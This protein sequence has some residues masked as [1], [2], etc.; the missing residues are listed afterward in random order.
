M[1]RPDGIVER[2]SDGT[3]QQVELKTK[4]SVNDN[5]IKGWEHDLQLIGQQ[6]GL[7]QWAND[8]ELG[9]RQLGGARIEVLLKG[10]RKRNKVGEM[11]QQ[12]PLIYA[13]T[14]DGAGDFLEAGTQQ[15]SWEW[16][17]RHTKRLASSLMPLQQWL[18][19]LPPEEIVSRCL[20]L[21]EINPTDD[22]IAIAKRQWG[23][24]AIRE[25]LGLQAV[26]LAGASEESLDEHFP[27]TTSYCFQMG[28]CSKFDLC[29]NPG[30]MAD[31]IG[32][33]KFIERV[34]NHPEGE[35]E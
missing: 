6:V 24:A 16:K 32:S 19:M 34:S 18:D 10:T 3:L 30:V 20:V 1:L 5:Y 28:K 35:S 2:R 23:F 14:K 22:E 11:E 9:D 33:G 13:Y 31:P 26:R 29:F 21:P 17:P 12:S 7:R 4:A 27:Q 15:T 8:N 25:W